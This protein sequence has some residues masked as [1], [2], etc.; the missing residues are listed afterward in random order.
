[1]SQSH[2]SPECDKC[3]KQNGLCYDLNNDDQADGCKC[4]LERSHQAQDKVTQLQTPCEVK[5]RE[6]SVDCNNGYVTICY[7]PHFAEPYDSLESDLRKGTAVARL[8][9][10]LGFM[11]KQNTLDTCELVSL[12]TL[13]SSSSTSSDGELPYGNNY[14]RFCKEVD[15]LNL[16]AEKHCGIRSYNLSVSCYF[17]LLLFSS[18]LCLS[19]CPAILFL[20]FFYF[21]STRQQILIKSNDAGRGVFPLFN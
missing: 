11:Q 10:T 12:T 1:A 17:F 4:P 16:Q 8:A 6:L 18:L 5:H 19:G 9:T 3:T 7:S 20:L 13:Q 21:S 14:T 2:L 15:T